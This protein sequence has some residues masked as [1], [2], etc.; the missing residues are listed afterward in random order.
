MC[1]RS[2]DRKIEPSRE[3]S[4]DTQCNV[5]CKLSLRAVASR[6]HARAVKAGAKAHVEDEI[7][8][9]RLHDDA[10]PAKGVVD[11]GVP[12]ISVEAIFTKSE[13]ATAGVCHSGAVAPEFI[14]NSWFAVPLASLCNPLPSL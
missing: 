8:V 7:R 1:V 3:R 2:G 6:K 4:S 10:V 11:R 12:D 14:L 5:T 13:L 9:E